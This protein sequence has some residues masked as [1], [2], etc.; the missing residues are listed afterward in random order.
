MIRLVLVAI[1]AAAL[2]APVGA[3]AQDSRPIPR[4]AAVF[5]EEMENDLDGYIRAAMLEKKAPLT[6]VLRREDA[7]LVIAGQSTATQKTAWHEGWLTTV[8]DKTEGNVMVFDRASKQLLV[9]VQAG[10]R[11]LLLGV[12]AKG[13]QRKVAERLVDKIKDQVRKN[14]GPIPAPP[15]LAREELVAGSSGATTAST[16]N[17]LMNQDVVAMVAAGLGTDVIVAKIRSS[18]KAFDTSTEGLLALKKAGVPDVII[19]QML[20]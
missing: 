10:D 12:W 11:S 15:P 17:R 9:A 7:H 18:A 4:G 2:F 5:V 6:V 8:K 13:G 1:I 19:A 3:T 16:E 20:N 14:P